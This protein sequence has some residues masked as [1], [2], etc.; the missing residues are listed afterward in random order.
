MPRQTPSPEIDCW[1]IVGQIQRVVLSLEHGL[2]REWTGQRATDP[3]VVELLEG[4]EMNDDDRGR[5]FDV[6]AHMA[7]IREKVARNCCIH[8]VLD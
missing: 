2:Q 3:E 1:V 4:V 6:K 8:E 7:R 5:N